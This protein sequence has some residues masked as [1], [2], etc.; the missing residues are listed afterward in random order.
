MYSIS[1]GYWLFPAHSSLADG[2]G[3]YYYCLV[4]CAFYICSSVVTLSNTYLAY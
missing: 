2:A 1:G 4:K 3:T